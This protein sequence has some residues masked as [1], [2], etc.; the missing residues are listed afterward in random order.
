MK[1]ITGRKHVR[2]ALAVL[3]LLPFAAGCSMGG[4]SPGT[5]AI[6]PPP[7]DLEEQ[8]VNAAADP[9]MASLASDSDGLT[10]Y[11]QDGNGFVAPMTLRLSE[12]ASGKS[13]EE[14]AIAWMTQGQVAAD[15]LPAGFTPLL[16]EG[17]KIRSVTKDE[18][19]SSVTIDFDGTFPAMPADQERKAIEALVWTM[20]ELPNVKQVLFTVDGE[21]LLLLPASKLP[22]DKTM[23]RSMGINVEQAAG[24]TPSRSMAVTLYFAAR[25]TDG[26]G[27]FVPVTRLVDRQPDKNRA[28]LQELISGPLNTNVLKPV[29]DSSI[30][31]DKVGEADGLLNV[32]L[33]DASWEPEMLVPATTVQAVVLTL[34]EVSGEPK[35]KLAI[36]G[37][38][39]FKDTNEQSYVEPISR[40]LEINA[41]ER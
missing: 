25:S 37:T 34:T 12:E 33:K 28:A 21:P 24:L 22:I 5:A 35:I 31:I 17:S 29:V 16:P 10:V 20:T 7:S 27:Y 18:Q 14:Q 11:L 23:S 39:S 30:A 26:E 4:S 13:K 6:D 15:Q 9:A 2:K 32:E 36:N 41:L 40:P 19:A 8:M 38:D 1:P 3:L